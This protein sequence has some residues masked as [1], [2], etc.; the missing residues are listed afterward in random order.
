[1]TGSIL[2]V[3][4]VATNRIMLKAALDSAQYDTM[5]C[6]SCVEA[7]ELVQEYQPDLLLINL[8]NPIEDSHSFCATLRKS[9]KNAHLA[10]IAV[11]VADTNEARLAALGANVDDVLPHP[12]SNSLLL[13]RIRGLLRRRSATLEWSMREETSRALGFQEEA[14]P[15]LTPQKVSF[16]RLGSKLT[17]QLTFCLNNSEIGSI[18]EMSIKEA[19]S[20][21]GEASSADVIVLDAHNFEDETQIYSLIAD[22]RSRKK[23]LHSEILVIVPHR[24]VKLAARLFDLGASDIAYSNASS[25]E[26][27]L[28]IEKLA[29]Q[30][31]AQDMQR[32]N[33][34]N[35]LHAAVTDSLTGL[36]NRRYAETHLS[37][38]AEQAKATGL[39]YALMVVDI[40]H[41][42][43]IND[44]YGHSAGDKVLVS[45]AEK[46]KSSFRAIDLV[47]RIGGE[48]FLI[49]MPNTRTA[50]AKIAAERLRRTVN[51]NSFQLTETDT[52]ISITISVGVA[53][54]VLKGQE[55][56]STEQLFER[57]DAAL[58]A[59]KSSGR[60]KVA[61]SQQ[62]A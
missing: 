16:V 17:D 35:G 61:I 36:Y 34:R 15:R 11:G 20:Q 22:L 40:D 55:N 2:V 38:I 44:R 18:T 29:T 14:A 33:V 58:Y 48:E 19:L 30:K 13:A 32:K 49:C 28:R 6:A 9:S 25:E 10:I 4:S 54:D 57:A 56:L 1:M 31:V 59:A 42:K 8:A 62:A 41:F 7:T 12:R 51:R 53:V 50:Q 3:D 5:T 43:T 26:L 27:V 47:A 24:Q 39:S 37:R 46:L 60:D 52:E 21:S 23:S 45:M